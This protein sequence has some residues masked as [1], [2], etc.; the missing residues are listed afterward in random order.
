MVILLVLALSCLVLLLPI[1]EG[2]PFY[3]ALPFAIILSIVCA[4]H[5]IPVASLYCQHLLLPHTYA[6]ISFRFSLLLFLFIFR[7]RR[8]KKAAHTH[9][10]LLKYEL[11]SIQL[12]FLFF[13][14]LRR[15]RLPVFFSSLSTRHTAIYN[16][17]LFM[18]H[19]VLCCTLLVEL[20]KKNLFFRELHGQC[21]CKREKWKK[22]KKRYVSKL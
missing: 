16:V 8:D 22:G 7:S 17:N 1:F 21:N 4:A 3:G 5:T 15:Q 19:S 18:S 6:R 2:G 11:S 14:L 20:L 9:T 10:H 13:L 12:Y